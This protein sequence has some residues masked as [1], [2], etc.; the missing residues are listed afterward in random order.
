VKNVP[1]S[2]FSIFS[3]KL[4]KGFVNFLVCLYG[5]S[6]VITGFNVSDPDVLYSLVIHQPIQLLQKSQNQDSLSQAN[7]LK[8]ITLINF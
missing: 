7:V 1:S 5:G 8:I 6:P 3:E 2:L 4:H